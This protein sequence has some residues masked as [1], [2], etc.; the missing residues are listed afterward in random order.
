MEDMNREV[1]TIT[2][3]RYWVPTPRRR[4]AATM[5]VISGAASASLVESSAG[6]VDTLALLA[7]AAIVAGI[8]TLWSP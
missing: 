1:D 7:V 8:S 5:A 4:I 3:R 2:L 6:D